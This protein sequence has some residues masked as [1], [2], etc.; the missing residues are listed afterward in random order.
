MNGNLISVAT[1][2]AALALTSSATAS[3]RLEPGKTDVVV[4]PDA[5]DVVRFA[6]TET[7]NFLSRVLGKPVPLVTT[8]DEAR[9]SLVLGD[10]GWS[11]AVGLKVGALPRDGFIARAEG[12]RV[13]L[14]GRDDPDGNP[15]LFNAGKW[16][17]LG[18]V[19]FERA[20]SF[21]V[22]DFLERYAGCRFLF[23]G[24]LGEVVPTAP[25]IDVPE[26]TR[27]EAP[28]FEERI[29]AMH[30]GGKWPGTDKPD[31]AK[32]R[33]NYF[34]QRYSTFR[35][36]AG[37]GQRFLRYSERF[38][39]THPEY[40]CLRKDGTRNFTDDAE[41]SW[42]NC[43]FCYTSGIWDEMY[44]DAKAYFSGEP[45]SVRGLR[46]WPTMGK[47]AD[48][49]FFNLMPEDS[50]QRCHC[51][52]CLRACRTNDINYA[53]EVI[54][55]GLAK[56]GF[57][58]KEE[59]VPGFITM[60]AYAPYG[61]LPDFPLPDNLLV[62]V[63]DGGPWSLKD[64]KTFDAE[65]GRIRGWSEKTRQKTWLW[66]Y[67][68]KYS[69]RFPDVPQICPRAY[70]R[71]F[72]TVSKWAT[73]GYSEID[74]DRYLYDAINVYVYSRLGWD[75]QLDI[76]AVLADL[77]GALFGAAAKPMD[78]AF[79][80]MEDRWLHRLKAY[81]IMNE[82]GPKQPLYPESYVWGR[83]YTPDFVTRVRKCFD[84]AAKAVSPGT[85][86]ERRVRLFRDEVF[87]PMAR[88]SAAYAQANG[89]VKA[90]IPYAP[91]LGVS[92]LG[93]LHLPPTVTKETPVV[94]AIHGGGW[95]GGD[96][97]SWS[98]VADFFQTNLNCA[99]FNI[100]YRLASKEN[101]WPA[102]GDDCVRAA[103]WL[104]SPAFTKVSGLKP[105]KIWICGGSAGGHLT[106]W[107]LVNLP[108]NKVAGAISI[109]SIGDPAPDAAVHG[110][111]YWTL[112]GRTP[113]AADFA[114]MDPRWRIGK[115]M[116]PVLC[117]HAKDDQVVPIASHRAFADAYREA[118]NVCSF[119]E[120][121]CDVRP[122]LSGH[123]IWLPG[124]NPHK[125]I[126]EIE[127]EIVRFVA[128]NRGR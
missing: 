43:K 96:R 8:I 106:L 34:R 23:P 67:T 83:V 7:T 109:S 86:A 75:P 44:L 30:R 111:R 28:V 77:Y 70:A 95:A 63:C 88:H 42:V 87:E 84:A 117:T 79:R 10:N 51:E 29:Y 24:E 49:R 94:L 68:G 126:P 13:Y 74:T 60:S 52:N 102:C 103:K 11:R 48:R 18:T 128:A 114:A 25:F 4:A 2:S 81:V 90:D 85:L 66:V 127:A 76:D 118:G 31:F 105:K 80:L 125:L 62:Q 55:G 91:E 93:D 47:G 112:F 58:L 119:F 27:T 1:L 26:G 36:P 39:K 122:K 72:S 56:L 12:R 65:I 59:K 73:G 54:W 45:P 40:F 124:S 61:E 9:T 37:H 123:C 89:W 82:R 57:K 92:G 15:L 46:K 115:G 6:A 78:Q 17:G 121:P 108:P 32:Q 53:N 120:Y 99:V 98:G 69:K 14:L 50:F 38:A 33:L 116:A 104:L 100:E 71:Y 5:C 16:S 21:A 101:R 22:Y 35:R 3:V 97:A 110:G 41:P 107:T 20:T 64:E 19:M 113:S